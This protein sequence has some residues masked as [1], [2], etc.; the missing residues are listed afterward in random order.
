MP[1][2]FGLVQTQLQTV[3]FRLET[4]GTLNDADNQNTLRFQCHN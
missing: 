1:G 2:K 3:S 4:V